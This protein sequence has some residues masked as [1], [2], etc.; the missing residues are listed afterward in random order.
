MNW[1][2]LDLVT[3]FWQGALKRD[4][5]SLRP[6]RFAWRFNNYMALLDQPSC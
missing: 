4:G 1:F 6:P 2:R 3:L 5:S